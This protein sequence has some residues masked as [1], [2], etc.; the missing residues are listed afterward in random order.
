MLCSLKMKSLLNPSFYTDPLT[1]GLNYL[2]F[3]V[4]IQ[5]SPYDDTLEFPTGLER[6][7]AY[8]TI[9]NGGSGNWYRTRGT[10]DRPQADSV[11]T[12]I[13][14]AESMAQQW[15]YGDTLVP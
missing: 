8:E 9:A 7:L 6:G 13:R 11:F 1:G 14:G 12:T 5:D 3:E 2:Q 10:G 15:L 4:T